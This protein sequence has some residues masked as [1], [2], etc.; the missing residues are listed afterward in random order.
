MSGF[1]ADWLA[2][3]EPADR[4]ARNDGIARMV[5]QSLAGAAHA[6]ICDLGAGTGSSLRALAPVLPVRQDWLLIDSDPALLAAARTALAGWADHADVADAGLA[7]AIGDRRIGVRLH[8]ADLR[9]DLDGLLPA[10]ADLINGSALI[11]LVSDAWLDRLVQAARRRGSM[12]LM[13][14]SYAGLETWT[15]PFPADAEMLAA[16]TAHQQGD[17]GFGPALGPRAAEV[18][19]RKLKRAGYEVVLAPS[20]W[21]LSTDREPALIAALAEG[22]AAAVGETGRLP[23]E[24]VAAW[25]AARR[26]AAA[27]EIAHID[28][29][30]RLP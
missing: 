2:L 20:P 24:R 27:V 3:R 25:R 7:F 5:A 11:D 28:L 17:K 16:F 19:S 1:S 6:S 14:L 30:A 26:A 15:P 4:R 10:A 22:I 9:D 29:F 21:R 12:V 8:Q 13:T 18:L 23:P